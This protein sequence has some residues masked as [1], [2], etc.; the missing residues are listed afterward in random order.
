MTT[1]QVAGGTKPTVREVL[2]PYAA[3][4]PAP[5]P[6]RPHAE[7]RGLDDAFPDRTVRRSGRPGVPGVPG[8]PEAAPLP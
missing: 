2:E 1:V 5:A 4:R 3:F 7:R 6:R 8:V